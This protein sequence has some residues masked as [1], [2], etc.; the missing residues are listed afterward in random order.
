MAIRTFLFQ[1][2][3]GYAG[4]A[5]IINEQGDARWSP[6]QPSWFSNQYFEYDNGGNGRLGQGQTAWRNLFFGTGAVRTPLTGEPSWFQNAGF[7]ETGTQ[8]N[9]SFALGS[10]SAVAIMFSPTSGTWE[11]ESTFSLPVLSDAVDTY[12]FG[13]GFQD[14]SNADLTVDG[15]YVRYRHDINGGRFQFVTVANGVRS[16][17]DTGIAV[18]AGDYYHIRVVVENNTT[19]SLW[20]KTTFS[21][22]TWSDDGVWGVPTATLSTTIPNGAAEVTGCGIAIL[23]QAGFTSR[24]YKM[25]YQMMRHTPVGVDQSP[26]MVRGRDATGAVKWLMPQSIAAPIVFYAYG[27]GGFNP[28]VSGDFGPVA[29]PSGVIDGTAQDNGALG[30]SRLRTG[31]NANGYI[32]Y[33]TSKSLCID[34]YT[35]P[36]VLEGVFSI[37]TL[38]TAAQ[39]FDL[40]A[41]IFDEYAITPANGIYV[42]VDSFV[43]GQAQFVC[44]NAGIETRTPSGVTIVAGAYY[45]WR[46]VVT[47]TQVDFYFGLDGG[48]DLS[49]PTASI[50]TNI[51]TTVTMQAGYVNQKLAGTTNRDV[52]YTYVL[53]YQR[54]TTS[55][56]AD[57]WTIEVMPDNNL[58]PTPQQAA[59]TYNVPQPR[60]QGFAMLDTAHLN[61][62]GSSDFGTGSGGDASEFD[63]DHPNPWTIYAGTQSDSHVAVGAGGG[64]NTMVF[65]STSGLRVYDIIFKVPELSD[66]LT[67]FFVRTGLAD[68]LFSTVTNGIYFELDSSVNPQGVIYTVANGTST[69]TPLGFTFLANTW[70]RMRMEI[71]NDDVVYVWCVEQGDPWPTSPMF[72]ITATLPSGVAQAV[73]PCFTIKKILGPDRDR[74][75]LTVFNMVVGCDRYAQLN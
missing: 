21:G 35:Q 40:L 43:A 49:S 71:Y 66:G 53:A 26:G 9:G 56:V 11:Y 30:T 38:S 18:V 12:I 73:Q 25:G 31:A 15:A 32:G 47:A 14:N 64:Q 59:L 42:D 63:A 13:T 67:Q 60:T 69:P 39:Q 34:S 54:S 46:I 65:S 70:Y 27:R 62:W 57:A 22:T 24:G 7:M 5:N 29:G 2:P 6:N 50:T 1:L 8:S 68:S 48:A 16:T 74:R 4:E 37:P 28:S 55:L 52:Y 41:G 51:P 75:A 3:E 19:A 61:I 44:K 23:K 58:N 45:F 36:M 17:A 10:A 20:I 33:L 72:T